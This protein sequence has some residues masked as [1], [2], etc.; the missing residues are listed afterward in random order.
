MRVADFPGGQTVAVYRPP[1]PV[2]DY[3]APEEPTQPV[4]LQPLRASLKLR[5]TKL[6]RNSAEQYKANLLDRWLRGAPLAENGGRNAALLA[7]TGMLAYALPG[8]SLGTYVRIMQPSID[9]MDLAEGSATAERMLLGAMRCKYLADKQED[10]VN[11]LW[12]QQV[13]AAYASMG[14]PYHKPNDRQ[15]TT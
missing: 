2:D 13:A 7:I 4:D 14:L 3:T 1:P 12:S 11:E 9:A 6:R 5:L 8:H 10:A 15:Q